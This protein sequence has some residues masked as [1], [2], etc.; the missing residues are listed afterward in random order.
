M[1]AVRTSAMRAALRPVRALPGGQARLATTGPT[2]PA[3]GAEIKGTAKTYNKDGTNPN[4]NLIYIG[5]GALAL[6]GVYAMFMA[7]PEKVA[8]TAK[9][10]DPG[11]VAHQ[12]AEGSQ[13]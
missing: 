3:D 1:S 6:G 8:E 9:K 2:K 12:R 7:K 4:K 11:A 10:T 5:A 13:R